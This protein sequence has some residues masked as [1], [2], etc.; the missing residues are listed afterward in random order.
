[1][2]TKQ[3]IKSI[4]YAMTGLMLCLF[5]SAL[6]YSIVATAMPQIIS[7]LGGMQY[8][9]LPFTSFLLFSTVVIP[10]AGKMSDIYGR[11]PV[12]LWGIV[13]F[14]ITSAMCGLSGNMLMLVIARGLQGACSGVLG[15]SSFIIVAEIFPP[16]ER[17]KYI[18][19]LASM[20]GLAS[21]SGPVAGGLITD[22]LSW[23]WIFFINIPIGIVA[24]FLLKQNIPLLRHPENASKL[25]IKGI[26]LFLAGIFPFLFCFSESGRMLSFTSPMTLGL[27]LVA[28]G[29]IILFVVAERKSKSP[30]LS[31]EMLSNKHF[32]NSVVG[33]SLAY[34]ALFGIV[35]YVP[36]LLQIIWKKGAA[37][38]GMTMLPMSL[39]MVIGGIVGGALVSKF[40]RY[41]LSG[42]VNLAIAF[43]G[44]SILLI[45]GQTIHLW[46]L[47]TG[48]FIT[49][50]GIGMNFPVI[51]MVPQSVFPQSKLGTVMSAIE[52]FQIMGGVV[53]SAIMGNMLQ[54]QPQGI[55]VLCLGAL[56][57]GVFCMTQFTDKE[58]REGFE[59]NLQP[60]EN[61]GAG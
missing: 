27:L 29:F 26:A 35:I 59:K 43:M 10:I 30:L 61:R 38:S 13:L 34:V 32:R 6:D 4:P 60:E 41:R 49:G 3:S 25:D 42:I 57:I 18:G 48:I 45:F 40:Q 17:G 47:V 36:Y 37:F 52:F 50:L 16:Q 12:V 19:I 8:Y 24:W 28:V 53:S 39:S 46:V 11:K 20:H 2:A 14:I 1:M 33:A 7:N 58:I 9:S 51:N 5:L 23:H 44:M 15:V 55:I 56:L 31:I 21:L 54:S 22:Y